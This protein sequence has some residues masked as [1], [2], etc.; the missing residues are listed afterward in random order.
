MDLGLKGKVALVAGA[1]KGLGYAVAQALA[2]EGANVSIS[3]RD[4]AA[5]ADAARQ[6]EGETGARVMSMAVDV[7]SKDAIDRWIADAAEQVRR[8]RRA[9]DQLRRAARRRRRV[10]STTRPGR[11][12]RTCCCSARSA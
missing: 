9:D 4:E 7:R 5:I 3:S 11:T 6:I 10:R 12:R 1:S 8:H 2:A